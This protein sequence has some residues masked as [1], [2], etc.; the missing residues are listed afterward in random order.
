MDRAAR[1]VLRHKVLLGLL[2]E[3]FDPDALGDP[4]RDLDS[5]RNRDIARR[6]AEQ[7][8]HQE[9]SVLRFLELSGDDFMEAG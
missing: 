9:A 8:S 6:M 3:G 5:P 2:D 1:R 7:L 4:T